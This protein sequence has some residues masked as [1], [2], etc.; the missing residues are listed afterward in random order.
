MLLLHCLTGVVRVLRVRVCTCP[1]IPVR[2]HVL[3][4]LALGIMLGYMFRDN[5]RV[6]VRVNV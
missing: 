1:G 6:I 4:S 2:V 3:G 5:V